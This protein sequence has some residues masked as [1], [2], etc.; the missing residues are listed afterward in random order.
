M[1]LKV[2][3]VKKTKNY[4]SIFFEKPSN[5]N[6]YPAQFLILKKGGDER[7]FTI[8]SSPTEE[9]LMITTRFGI[10]NFKKYLAN[11][12]PGGLIESGPP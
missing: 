2:K 3:A 12:K 10:S 5:F 6:Y 9:D 4:F 7:E 1:I 8:A 11:L